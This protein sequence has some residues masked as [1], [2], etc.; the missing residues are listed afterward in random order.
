MS[1]RKL[2]LFLGIIFVISGLGLSFLWFNRVTTQAPK[3]AQSVPKGPAVLTALHALPSGTLLRDGDIGWKEV[4]PSQIRPGQ[5]LRSEVSETEY[6]GAIT[7]R[8]FAEGE[9]LTANDLVKPSDRR[10]LSAVLQPGKR[11]VS[12]Q[13][14]APNSASG[15]VLPGDFV[16]VILTQNFGDNITSSANRSV[17]ETV[18]HDI[19]V[20]AVEQ[21]TGERAEAP[22]KSGAEPRIPKTISLEVNERDAQALLVAKEL[23]KI[24]LAVRALEGSGAERSGKQPHPGPV[25]AH[26]VSQAVAVLA[27]IAAA[28]REAEQKAADKKAAEEKEEKQ[29]EAEDGTGSQAATPSGGQANTPLAQ[30][31]RELLRSTGSPIVRSIRCAPL[32]E[33]AADA[34]ES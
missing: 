34:G 29:R 15:L 30:C 18:L 33:S 8:D 31:A 16:D 21:A 6:L 10:F 25:W 32:T 1:V 5:L 24:H 28:K 20:V 4:P 3:V 9:A 27:N 17:G 19:R 23:G 12:I 22:A 26:D 11:A 13:V 14:D 2:L 7:R